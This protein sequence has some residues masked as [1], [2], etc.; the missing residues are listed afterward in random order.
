M[1][2]LQTS[3]IKKILYSMKLVFMVLNIYIKKY[4]IV[5]KISILTYI[6]LYSMKLVCIIK[7]IKKKY[8]IVLIAQCKD[9]KK[10]KVMKILC[11]IKLVFMILNIKKCTL[12]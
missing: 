4:R 6:I 7:Y 11:S 1:K 2:I 5:F 9:L 12:Y 3:K 8:H 10:V